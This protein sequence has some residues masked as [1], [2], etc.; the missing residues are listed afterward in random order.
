MI[1]VRTYIDST[2]VSQMLHG[3]EIWWNAT[4]DTDHTQFEPGPAGMPNLT[5]LEQLMPEGDRPKH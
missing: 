1:K 4:R 5:E 2:R 3:N